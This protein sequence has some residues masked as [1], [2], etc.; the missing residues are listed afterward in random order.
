MVIIK[1]RTMLF[2]NREQYIGTTYDNNSSVRTFKINRVTIDGIDIAHLA[3]YINIT[4]MDG[5]S[6]TDVLEKEV[7]EEEI[8]LSWKIDQDMIKKSSGTAFLNIRAHDEAGLVKWSTY[9]APVYIGSVADLPEIAGE[10]LHILEKLENS[11]LAV[12]NSEKERVYSESI[13]VSNEEIRKQNEEIRK[14]NE[15]IR[16]KQENDR[17]EQREKLQILMDNLLPYI[18]EDTNTWMIYNPESGEYEDTGYAATGNLGDM[19]NRILAEANARASAIATEK[20]ERQEEIAVERARING[21]LAL[22]DG[23]TTNDARLEDICIGVDGNTYDSPGEAV[24]GQVSAL[25]SDLTHKIDYPTMSDNDKILRAKDGDVEW[26]EVGQP[27]DEQ[28]ESAVNNWLNQHPEATTTVQDGAITESKINTDFLHYIKNC[29]VTPEMFGA[30]GDGI[31]DDTEPINS[32]LNYASD[33]GKV[34]FFQKGVYLVSSTLSIKPNTSIIGLNPRDSTIKLADNSNC[35]LMCFSGD[36]FSKSGI[37]IRDITLEGDYEYQTNT[38]KSLTGYGLKIENCGDIDA[39][40][41]F[42]V[43]IQ[44][45]AQSGLYIGQRSW[46]VKLSNCVLCRNAEYGYYGD[47]ASDNIFSNMAINQNG[48]GGI[49]Q[50]YGAFNKWINSKIY[51]NSRYHADLNVKRQACGI[52]LLQNNHDMFC[53]CDI[54]EN[55]AYGMVLN[56]CE[57]VILN[58]LD[59]DANGYEQTESVFSNLYLYSSRYITGQVVF[60][61]GRGKLLDHVRISQNSPNN[62]IS[63]K[64][65][66]EKT[67]SADKL[68]NFENKVNIDNTIVFNEILGKSF[69]HEM[70]V[71]SESNFAN[72]E[73]FEK[74]DIT[75]PSFY[76]YKPVEAIVV[77]DYYASFGIASIVRE[78]VAHIKIETSSS[79]LSDSVKPLKLLIRYEACT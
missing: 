1:N 52:Y 25:K 11:V 71:E 27:T 30:K 72:V 33:I 68:I 2:S 73:M 4:R 51:L 56:G 54:Q 34:L 79:A 20:S 32:A 39:L 37:T 59:F 29:Y 42:N 38:K 62:I 40:S 74:Y 7:N 66:T 46:T 12:I 6:D 49:Y 55:Y 24:R 45:F 78:H 5:S 26:V 77:T 36:V 76:K 41:V 35:D 60:V 15:E 48:I 61:N 28:T 21:L 75:I 50:H 47:G 18:N 63:Y 31:T 13:R 43:I 17:E 8:I 16:K 10:P 57:G 22:P 67:S 44:K 58:G 23:S 9:M 65:N 69:T 3:F 53:N 70:I 64:T 19:M 14:Q